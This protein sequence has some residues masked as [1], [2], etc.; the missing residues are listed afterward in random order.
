MIQENKLDLSAQELRW[1]TNIAV[2]KKISKRKSPREWRAK[3]R[4]VL[5]FLGIPAGCIEITELKR[6]CY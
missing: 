5:L 2:V 3:N 4:L 6:S 1:N